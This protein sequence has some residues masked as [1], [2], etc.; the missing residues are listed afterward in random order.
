VENG[1]A[2][3][4]GDEGGDMGIS[5]RPAHDDPLKNDPAG[6]WLLRVNRTHVPARYQKNSSPIDLAQ[7]HRP[8]DAFGFEQLHGFGFGRLK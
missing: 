3:D 6:V 5:A 4:A 1:L 7:Q 2:A 8:F